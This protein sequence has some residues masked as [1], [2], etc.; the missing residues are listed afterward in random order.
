M[1][2]FEALRPLLERICTALPDAG[3]IYLVGGAVRDLFRVQPTHD[4]DFALPRQAIAAGRQVANALGGDFYI[5]DSQ[6]DTGRVLL[7]SV[8]QERLILDF[9]AFRKPGLHADLLDRDFT[10]NA[11]A[12]NAR[13]PETL[14]DP[15]G[16]VSDLRSRL[17]RTC[18][19]ESFRQDP[20]RI[21]RAVRQ[22]VQFEFRILPETITLL[23][24]A[25]PF[26]DEVSAERLRD[27]LF[28]MLDGPNPTAAIRL[29]DKLGALEPILPEAAT[30][31]S[32]RQP[33]QKDNL[34]EL[35]LNTLQQLA[36]LIKVLQPEHDP[37][38][39]ANWTMGL[40]SVQ[41][42]RYRGPLQEHLGTPLNPE[43]SLLSLLL[44]AALYHNSG[45]S[46]QP[47]ASEDASP[48]NQA[49]A[50]ANLAALRAGELR[51]SNLEIDR[52]ST[53]IRLQTRPEQMIA[54]S[55]KPTRLE[56]YRF[57]RETGASGVDICLL[58]LAKRLATYGPEMPQVVWAQTLAVVRAL[59]EAYWEQT[60]EIVAPPALVNGNDL[61]RF[62]DIPSGPLIGEI[63]ETIRENQAIGEIADRDAALKLAR[64]LLAK[65]ERGRPKSTS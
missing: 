29:L 35:S 16:G 41:L 58:T 28:R 6:R 65:Q 64:D 49:A 50:G 20:V 19:P 52:L 2:S 34:L 37:E 43:R 11:I 3:E 51:L 23:R 60:A 13:N 25:T 24:R 47:K 17:L 55:L 61:I 63:L 15:L 38:G 7:H 26:L 21:L 59:L 4:L 9:A 48:E 22:A 8:S 44:L 18:S 36:A 30:L 62:L 12:L 42:G 14:I 33:A 53:T 46:E 56:M 57:F 10:V 40:A 54:R 45:A 31:K 27:E 5:L 39:A 32:L 1:N